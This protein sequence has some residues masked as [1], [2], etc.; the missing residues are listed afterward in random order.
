MMGEQ[1]PTE[2]GIATS[3]PRS[4]KIW[5]RRSVM[6]EGSTD[7]ASFGLFVGSGGGDPAS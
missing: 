5:A 3:P 6:T 4:I 7:K 1:L 2:G